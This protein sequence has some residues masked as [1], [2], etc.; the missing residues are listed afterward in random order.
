MR[1]SARRGRANRIFLCADVKRLLPLLV[2]AS[3]ASL[4]F[5]SHTRLRLERISPSEDGKLLVY[6]SIVELEGNLGDDKAAPAFTLKINGKSVGHPEKAA[7][8]RMAGEPLDLV[9]VVETSALYGP[10][11]VAP[12][13]APPPPPPSKTKGKKGSVK[14]PQKG[15]SKQPTPAPAPAPAPVIAPGDLPLDRVKDALHQ[16]LESMP[17]KSRVLV[18]DYGGDVT[19]HPPFRPATSAGGAVD[20]LS[21]DDESGD[22]VMVNAVKAALLELNKPRPDEAVPARRLIVVVSDGLNST[23]D[24]KT[25]RLLGE[26]ASKSHVPIHTIAYSPNDERGPLLNLG[27]ISKLSNGTFRWARNADALH[28]Q[29]ETLADELNKQYVLTFNTSLSSLEGKRFTLSVEDLDSNVLVYGADI[30]APRNFAWGFWLIILAGVL[31]VGGAI[32]V[33]VTRPKKRFATTR[34]PGASVGPAAQMRSPVAPQQQAP[35]Q[36]GHQP[37]Q[38]IAVPAARAPSRGVV[39]V[40]SGGLSGQRFVLGPTPITVGKGPSNIQI[41]D[42]PTVSTRHAQLYQAGADFVVADLGSTNG[43]FVNNQRVTQPTRLGDGDLV[44]FGNTQIKFRTE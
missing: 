33:V 32:V 2:I 3:L 34:V 15:K 36:T 17:P 35:R 14:T 38:P 44:R 43:T 5:A 7:R 8:F 6:A 13:P 24:R 26:A 11:K 25:F 9:L 30:K 39:V 1:A 28:D 12:P 20:D 40:A 23:M 21:P 18:I 31:A 19:P 41:T 4:A 10:Q 22:L 42:D 37:I 16:L 27:E 29:I